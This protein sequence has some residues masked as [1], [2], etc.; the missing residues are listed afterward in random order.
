MKKEMNPWLH[1]TYRT[2]LD[3]RSMPHLRTNAPSILTAW[4]PILTK[5]TKHKM[6]IN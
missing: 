6:L 4:S 1:L 5:I 2:A 3:R